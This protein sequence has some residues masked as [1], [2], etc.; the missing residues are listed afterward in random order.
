MHRAAP[1]E[2]KPAKLKTHTSSLW[3]SE[4]LI[5]KKLE[6]WAVEE[7]AV[8]EHFKETLAVSRHQRPR[9]SVVLNECK[10]LVLLSD[11]MSIS[12]LSGEAQSPDDAGR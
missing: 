10:R 5:E 9:Q 7:E 12:L 11:N 3:V 4:T 1:R 2:C 6:L 8:L